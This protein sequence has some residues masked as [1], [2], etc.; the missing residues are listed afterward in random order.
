VLFDWSAQPF[1]TLVL[2]FLFAP[3]FANVVAP[4]S[5][6]GQSYWGYG[7]AVAGL[8]I[9]IGSP[10][11]G[12]I[13]DGRGRRKP[14]IALFSLVFVA[15]MSA[16]WFATPQASMATIVGVLAAFVVAMVA[17]EFA[18]VFTNAIMP[19]LVPS[20]EM[21]RLSGNSYAA[22]YAGGL[23]SLALVSAFLIQVPESGK[24]MLGFA[25]PIP[26][27]ATARE[28]ERLI[29]AFSAIWYLVFIIPFF[30]FVP[31]RKPLSTGAAHPALSE[32]WNTIKSLPS[33]PSMLLFLIARMLYADGLAAIF[34]FGGIY[35][36]AMFNWSQ[37]ELGIFGIIVVVTGVIGAII[38]GKLDDKLGSKTVIVSC[39]LLLIAA[40]AGILSVDRTHAFYT[41][42]LPPKDP[43]A[44]PL[45]S[46]GER[47]YLGF[48]MLVGLVAAPVQAASRS[49]LARLAP[50]DKVT[51]FFGLFAFSGKATAFMAPFLI[52]IVTEMTNDQR[53][54][55]SAIALFLIVG[56]LLMLPVRSPR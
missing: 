32:L 17:I 23:V 52:G 31:D 28:G 20:S 3:Y 5:Q 38:G 24:T 15:A 36:T 48:A 27:D 2:T 14:W 54:G 51:Q 10:L 1:Y 42:E 29:G 12:A 44:G 22:G 46:I 45:S 25:S 21:G 6:L 26:L 34:T 16:L 37:L 40:L 47:I 13:A 35:G 39:L 55:M 8:I 4:S 30:L 49:L 43:S 41:L 56:A 19:G 33:H 7:A 11:L 50:P 18:S 53:L 9:A